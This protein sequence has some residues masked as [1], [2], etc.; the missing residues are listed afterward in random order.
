MINQILLCGNGYVGSAFANEMTERKISFQF[1]QRSIYSNFVNLAQRLLREKPSL[2]INAAAYVPASGVDACEHDKPQTLQTNLML[3]AMMATAC[4]WMG[5]PLMHIS[6]GCFYNGDNGGEGFS[7]LETPHLS[8][9]T[10]CGVYVGSKCLAEE[11]VSRYEKAYCL[12]IRLPFDE[13]DNPRNLLTKLQAYP[14]IVDE[15]QSVTHRVDFVK[16]ALDLWEMG[17]TPGIYNCTNPG[18]INYKAI[19]AK[20]QDKLWAGRRGFNFVSPEWFDANIAGTPKSRCTLSVKKLL[21]T[22]V[23]MR[24]VDEAVEDSINNWT[25]S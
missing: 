6:S 19:C 17:A 7:E 1:C 12:R 22:G 10:K 9:R 16:A 14:K 3:P 20:L 21:A 15:T 8:F 2:V 25:I 18:A 5:I 23:K 24:H 11:I 4:E 13:F